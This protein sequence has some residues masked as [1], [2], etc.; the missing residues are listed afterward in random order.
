MRGTVLMLAV[1]VAAVGV[2]GCLLPQETP[3]TPAGAVDAPAL[4][5]QRCA[6]CHSLDRVNKARFD[7]AQWERT[8]ALMERRGARLNDAERA[9]LIAQ[10]AAG[11]AG[12]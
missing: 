6:I 2:V 7:R 8:I 9:A 11:A 5:K 4:L 12:P 10:L 3:L 1:T